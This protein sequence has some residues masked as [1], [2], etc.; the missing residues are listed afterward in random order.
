MYNMAHT[1]MCSSGVVLKVDAQSYHQGMPSHPRGP[2][3]LQLFSACGSE[4]CV[5]NSMFLTRVGRY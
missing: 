4:F 5:H 1:F 3:L 2:F